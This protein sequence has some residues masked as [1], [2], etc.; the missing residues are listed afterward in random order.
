MRSALMGILALVAFALP[1]TASVPTGTVHFQSV[2]N[3]KFVRAGVTHSTLLAAV[4]PH[5]RGWETFEITE[6][7]STR[8]SNGEAF[9]RTYAIRSMQN[10]KYVRAGVGQGSLLAAVSPHIRAWEKFHIIEQGDGT[11]VLKSAHSG[12]IVRGGGY[13]AASAGRTVD[14]E[15]FRLIPR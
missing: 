13:L 15:K 7:P 8:D 11:V 4:S 2:Q 6:V 12:M 1:A 14:G 5:V 3:G 10:G 9:T